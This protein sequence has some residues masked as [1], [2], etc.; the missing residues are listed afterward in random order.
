MTDPHITPSVLAA[1][2]AGGVDALLAALVTD[3]LS[4]LVV[5]YLYDLWLRPEQQLPRHNWRYCVLR[6]GRGWGKTFVA[7]VYVNGEVEA[8]RARSVVLMGINE[9]RVDEVQIKSLIEAAPPWFKPVRERGGLTWP[10]GVRAE[11]FT[12]EAPEAVRSQNADLAWL[13]EI[14]GWSQSTRKRAFDNVTTATR[15]GRAQIIV[16]TTAQ[17]VND[18]ITELN[19]MCERDPHIN[20]R[21]DGTTFDNPM[22]SPEYLRSEA[23]KYVEGSRRYQE[24]LEGKDFGQAAGAL[25]DEAGIKATRRP[26]PPSDP[27]VVLIGLDPAYS[28]Q[29][30]AD[31]TGIIAA[32]RKAGHV[33]WTHDFSGVMDPEVWAALA[34]ETAVELKATG[35]VIEVNS[36]ANLVPTILKSA[37]KSHVTPAHPQG[38]ALEKVELDKPFPARRPG[39]LFYKMI[40]SRSDKYARAVGPSGETKADRLHVCGQLP[41]LEAQLVSVAP[42]AKGKS[43]GAYDAA[44]H[45]ANELAGLTRPDKPAPPPVTDAANAVAKL[46]AQLAAAAA[47]RRVGM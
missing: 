9:D 21:I 4:A 8:G 46:N 24:E 32:S 37:A 39:K 44:I 34:I 47:S 12:P 31:E 14:V 43:P 3:E 36:T 35:F 26:L 40:V 20:V 38:L 13:T 7:A 2:A 17:G 42:D 10:N 11:V 6:A 25:W 18:V 27:E 19:V 1:H 45:V 5:P 28:D 22:F 30:N 16:D 41:N 15:S 29:A 23:L 33:Y